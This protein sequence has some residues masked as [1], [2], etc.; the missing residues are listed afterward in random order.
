MQILDGPEELVDSYRFA[1]YLVRC[2]VRR[3]RFTELG[4]AAD[5][6]GSQQGEHGLRIVLLQLALL[7]LLNRPRGLAHV[8]HCIAELLQLL[9]TR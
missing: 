3:Y 6:L 2:E 7:P 5:T 8:V 1:G 4:A 9:S